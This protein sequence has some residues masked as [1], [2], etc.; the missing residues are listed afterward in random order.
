[1]FFWK[2][3]NVKLCIMPNRFAQLKIVFI[4]KGILT[5][6]IQQIFTFFLYSKKIN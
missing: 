2:I 6:F 5:F 4:I 3:I 1:M